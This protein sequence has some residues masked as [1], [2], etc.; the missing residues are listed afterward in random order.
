MF[1]RRP[2]ATLVRDLSATRRFM[3]ILSPR[4]ND[5]LVWFQVDVEVERAL[6]WA[7]E[8]SAARD[9]LR[10]I[11]LFHV[12]LA[13][14]ARILHERPRL[15]RFT[16]GGRLWQREGIWITFSAKMRFDDEAPLL[17]VKRRVDPT[18][19]VEAMVDALLASLESGRRGEATTSDREVAGL[20]SLP[21]LLARIATRLADV[22]DSF[23]L[24]PRV[25]LEADP[26]NA[27]VF[28][29]N[30]GSVGLEA[31]YHHLWEHGNC[32][33]F[34]VIGRIKPGPNGRRVAT[35][36]FTYDER[37][38]DGLYCARSLDR[39]RELIERPEKLDGG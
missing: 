36:K 6:D 21:P 20:L 7:K 27:S 30:L 2:D 31:G 11:T 37:V 33:I 13:A 24:L 23:G 10:P 35:L 1:G 22:A 12:I 5:N 26:L 4:R 17:T 15:N 29:A 9:P 25:M 34:C 18:L 16:A 38:E 19:P 8:R 14:L 3:P 28:V 39:L 32:P